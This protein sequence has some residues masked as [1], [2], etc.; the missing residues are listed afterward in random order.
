MTKKIIL[1]TLFF[2]GV[3]WV[4]ICQATPPTPTFLDF[5][6]LSGSYSALGG[7]TYQ[8]L[9]TLSAG[10]QF[11][12]PGSGLSHW[13]IELLEEKIPT[14]SNFNPDDPNSSDDVE[15]YF[16]ENHGPVGIYTTLGNLFNIHHYGVKWNYDDLITYSFIS[17]HGPVLDENGNV[18]FGAYSWMAK[19]GQYYDYGTTL[20]PNGH[21]IVPE[22]ATMSLLG[23][24]LIGLLGLKKRRG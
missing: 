23:L 15:T 12:T 11:G 5:I 19:G 6:N 21:D 18:D 17:T 20:G 13:W 9:Y 3:S 16:N 24:G 4:N 14:L 1:I 2:L 8:Y 10:P 7:G 22:P